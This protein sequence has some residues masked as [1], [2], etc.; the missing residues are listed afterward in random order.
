MQDKSVGLQEIISI[1]H[2]NNTEVG[3]WTNLNTGESL[4][5]EDG[6]HK[7][8][9]AEKLCLVHS[10]ISEALTAF[11]DNSQDEKLPHRSGL[12]V[13]LADATIR[14]F[15]LS[16][17]LGLDLTGAILEKIEYNKTRSDHQ[18]EN[19]LNGTGKKF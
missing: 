8:N 14:I 19:R 12:E 2:K 4:K 6:I 17:G 9:I 15:D 10:E 13:E 5:S 3:W 16:M 11:R 7:I 18:I 1:I